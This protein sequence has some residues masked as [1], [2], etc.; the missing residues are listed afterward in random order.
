M[1]GMGAWRWDVGM[2]VRSVCRYGDV[3]NTRECRYWDIENT[4]EC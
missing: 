2:I 1:S 4:Q 3:D